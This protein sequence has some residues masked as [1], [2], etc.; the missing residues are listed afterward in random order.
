MV[1]HHNDLR[2]IINWAYQWKMSFQPRPSQT[3]S[4]GIFSGKITK[5]NHPT[6]IFNGNPVHQVS[7]RKHL[8]M[9]LDCKQNFE[10]HLKILKL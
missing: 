9:F 7:L 2:K 10:E 1:R 5:T 4:V 6:L 8:E 3:S